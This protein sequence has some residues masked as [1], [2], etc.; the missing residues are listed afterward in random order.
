MTTLPIQLAHGTSSKVNPGDSVIA[1]QKIA[2]R[3]SQTDYIIN[4]VNEFS[5]P[6]EKVR[7]LLKVKPGDQ[8]RPGDILAVKKNL[9]G[10]SEVRIISKVSGTF[11]RYERDTGNLVIALDTE[12]SIEDIVSPV[13]GIVQMCDNN[14]II[15]GTEK[16]VFIGTKGAG[17]NASGE[18]YILEGAFPRE[19]KNSKESDISLYYDL[20]SRAI[21]KIIIGGVFPRDFLIKSIG[22]GAAGIIGNAIK[23]ED[24]EYLTHRHLQVPI[25]EIDN[26]QIKQILKWKNKKL[27]LN[28]REKAVIVL[29]A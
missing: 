13:D 29:H 26:S 28:T 7:K 3:S 19:D 10:L 1:G 23:D 4:L 9:L 21:G 20:D 25:I 2:E 16:D 12:K 22:M 27:F 11:S 24:I 6:S 8:V 18:V 14:K 5:F 17:G 15:I